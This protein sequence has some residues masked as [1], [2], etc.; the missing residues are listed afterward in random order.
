MRNKQ[1][2]IYLDDKSREILDWYCK[3]H[4]MKMSKAI[5]DIIQKNNDDVII[6]KF[7][8][9]MDNKYKN[10]FTGIRLSSRESDKTSQIIL[11]TLNSLLYSV[12]TIEHHNEEHIVI[13]N[14]K[15]D[16]KTKIEHFKQNKD[17]KKIKR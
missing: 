14:A 7:I 4:N 5:N 17:S 11:S 6:D 13:Q 16:L 9:A 2:T 1:T 3:K 15:K 12:N 10:M 8:I